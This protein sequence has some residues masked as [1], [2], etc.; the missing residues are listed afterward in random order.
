MSPRTVRTAAWTAVFV[1]AAVP[2]V[3]RR[4][5][6]PAPVT[7]GAAATA[8]LALAIAKP[9]SRKRDVVIYALQMWA[10][11]AAYQV[12]NDNPEKLMRRTR[13]D[14]PVRIDRWLGLGKH[15]N[16]RVQ[17]LL[18]R[19]GRV[20]RFEKL[21][22]WVHWTWI[23]EPHLANVYVMFKHPDRFPRSAAM[24]CG[25]FDVGAIFYWLIPTAPPWYASQEGR[26][27]DVDRI[28]VPVGEEFWGSAWP[29]LKG[30]FGGNPVAAM[31]SLHFAASVMAAKM[32]AETGSVA[33][34]FGWGY[35][36]TLGFA[37]VYLGEH[38]LIDLA[39]GYAL[40]AAVERLGPRAGPMLERLSREIQAL[41]ARA[42]EAPPLGWRTMPAEVMK[43]L[44][45][46]REDAGAL[47]GALRERIGSLAANGAER[48]LPPAR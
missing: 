7:L 28:M 30:F 33:G 29:G 13:V 2:L 24:V 48:V 37:L 1:G 4:L 26:M 5:R 19:R 21:L 43:D 47:G 44:G 16:V 3:R 12:P 22:V 15:P 17:R 35:A 45:D 6:L 31:P 34:A 11:I 42:S 10:F 36:L 46:V 38:Y 40:A 20:R 9:R 27:P 39:A 41:E 14:Y 8:P 18:W 32:L 25:T 23:L